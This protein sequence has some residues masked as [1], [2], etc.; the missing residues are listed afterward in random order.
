MAKVERSSGASKKLVNRMAEIRKMWGK[1]K[2]KR[3]T[4]LPDD[5]Y[6]GKITA[7]DIGVS[8][9]D[10][11][12]AVIEITVITGDA[13]GRTIRKYDG[14]ETQDNLDYFFGFLDV[15][16]VDIP[17]ADEFDDDKA[18]VKAARKAVTACIGKKVDFSVRTKD[19]FTNVYVNELLEVAGT[20]DDDAEEPED[21]D[22]EEDADD[23]DEDE[24]DDEEDAP[25][26]KKAKTS[27]KAS[28]KTSK[29]KKKAEPDFACPECGEGVRA[30]DKACPGC[31]AEFEED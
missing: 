20:D 22:D 6:Q 3:G 16:E 24:D 2:P 23:E 4:T 18:F 27:S 8:R 1:A 5:D 14:L 30:S 31:G 21:E 13:K 26:P 25:P 7:A 29:K 17:D 15:C 19:D 12:Q 9:S 10:R 11:L 28:K